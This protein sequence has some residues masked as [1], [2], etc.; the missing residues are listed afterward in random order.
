MKNQI[1]NIFCCSGGNDSVALIQLAHELKMKNIVVLYN[2]TGW[3]IPWW[4]DRMN[5]IKNLCAKYKFKYAE[6]KS[7]GFK[8]MVRKKKGFPMAA[9]KIQ[10]CSDFL[11]TQPTNDWLLKHDPRFQAVIYIGIRREE[12]QNRANHPRSIIADMR[13]Y[14]RA[15][16]F[17]LVEYKTK[18]RDFLIDRSGLDILLH[19][20]MECFPCVNSNRADFR[21]LAQYPERINM[22]AD[23]EKE[24]GFTGKGKPRVMFRPYRHMGAIGIKE[25][26]K[27]GLCDRGKYKKVA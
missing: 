19:S 24:M 23:L 1:L 25:V 21:H 6:T 13:Y 26:V 7:I 17:P 20:S 14:G 15:M 4:S 16:E 9:S 5:Q 12:S 2:D 11:K 8:N 22:L 18:E 3:A 27:W 10:F